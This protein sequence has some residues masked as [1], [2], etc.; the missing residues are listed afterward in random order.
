MPFVDTQS[1]AC[2]LLGNIINVA[3]S[4]NFTGR[5]EIFRTQI[6][7]RSSP[8]CCISGLIMV[9]CSVPLLR[10]VRYSRDMFNRSPLQ[11]SSTK[12]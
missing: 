10:T 3:L 5:T 1:G 9:S 12:C 2:L 8:Y 6:L 4:F 7:D 11:L